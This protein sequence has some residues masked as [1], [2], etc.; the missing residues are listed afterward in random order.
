MIR[1]GIIVGLALLVSLALAKT[2]AAQEDKKGF[3][4]EDK[5][6]KDDPRDKVL[7]ASAQKVHN[8]KMSA[9]TIYAI[10]MKSKDFDTFL[11]L[12]DAAGKKLDEDDDGGEG[13][14][15]RLFFEAPKDGMYRIVC[16]SFDGKNG[17]FTLTVRIATKDEL[18]KA[19]PHRFLI[20]K[21]APEIV[22]DGCVNG[23]VTRL[24]DLKGKVVL[25]DFWAVWCGPCIAT[26]P[27]LREW[28]TAHAKEG[29]VVLG[30]TTYYQRYGFDSDKGKLTSLKEE[31][32]GAAAE[33]DMVKSF[34]EFHKLTHPLL[35]CPRPDYNRASKEYAVRG[36]PTAVL[37]DRDGLVR[38]IRVGSGPANAEALHEEM[39]KLLARK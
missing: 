16:T 5:L 24:S 22:G 3:K 2:A 25:L 28:S 15:S 33:R 37:I 11:R 36:I 19:N 34:A 39:K 27:H 20:G 32:L 4:V 13:S 7:K 18:V 6:T 14:N 30:V 12:E 31:K 23:T 17:A 1:Y 21:P 9:G 29:L 38:L 10:D 8:Y 35:M 26:F